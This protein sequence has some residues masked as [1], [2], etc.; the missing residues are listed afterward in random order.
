VTDDV[1]F[2]PSGSFV[3]VTDEEVADVVFGDRSIE[4]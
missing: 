4:N 1:A 3:A 2:G